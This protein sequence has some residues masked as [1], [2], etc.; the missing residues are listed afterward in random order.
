MLSVV[1]RHGYV[2]LT[3]LRI[4]PMTNFAQDHA[5]C[6]IKANGQAAPGKSIH[7]NLERAI[8]HAQ[9]HQYQ[10]KP[11]IRVQSEKRIGLVILALFHIS[12]PVGRF[13]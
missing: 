13:S 3:K 12:R 4:T 7:I 9:A 11:P 1:A 10:D 5:T 6:A 2:L 8:D